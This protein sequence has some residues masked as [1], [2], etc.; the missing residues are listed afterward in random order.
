MLAAI[1][2]EYDKGRLLLIGTTDLLDARRPVI[3]NIGAIAAS[4]LPQAL[5]L[6]RKILL[7]SAAIPAMFPP[8]LINVEVDDQ[9]YQEMHVDGA[10]I[11]QKSLIGGRPS[12]LGVTTEHRQCA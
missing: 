12:P 8:A 2:R 1:G 10:A 7:A 9:R 3:W 5:D 6:F 4:G 11:A